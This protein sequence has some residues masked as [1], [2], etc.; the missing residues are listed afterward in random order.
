MPANMS[1]PP[2]IV[3]SFGFVIS[4]LGVLAAQ[5]LIT[6]AGADRAHASCLGTKLPDRGRQL[7]SGAYYDI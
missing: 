4:P 6:L 1:R 2:L 5:M 3:S 7:A